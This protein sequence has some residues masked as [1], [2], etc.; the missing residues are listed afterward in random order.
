LR[1]RT[2]ANGSPVYPSESSRYSGGMRL[3]RRAL[4]AML[5]LTASGLGA[6]CYVYRQPLR[7]QWALYRIG[8]AASPQEAD[9]EIVGCLAGPDHNAMI[10]EMVGKWGTGNRPFDLHLATHLGAGTCGEPLRMAFAAELGRRAGLLDRWAHYWTWRAQLPPEQQMASLVAYFDALLAADPPRDIT[11]RDVL[12]L[13]ALFQ[14]TGRGELARNLSPNNWR[15][16]YAQWQRS[17]PAQLSRIPR[18][19]EPF[20]KE[21]MNAK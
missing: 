13:E 15:D 14:L 16:R 19:E 4:L 9:R 5:V 10:G 1:L 2:Q 20:P 17:R 7:R 11:W 12:D 6:W 3:F 21:M 8:A 18:P